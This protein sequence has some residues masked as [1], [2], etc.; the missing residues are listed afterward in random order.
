MMNMTQATLLS[1]AHHFAERFIFYLKLYD[2]GY[3]NE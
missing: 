3:N 2:N 1:V